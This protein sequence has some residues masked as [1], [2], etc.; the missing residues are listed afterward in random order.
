MTDSRLPLYRRR[1]VGI[2]VSRMTLAGLELILLR[3]LQE[4]SAYRKCFLHLTPLSDKDGI[5]EA[6]VAVFGAVA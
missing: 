2:F 5:V 1:K 6:F 3:N 4:K